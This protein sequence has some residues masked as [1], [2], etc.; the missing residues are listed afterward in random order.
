MLR[1]HHHEHVD[2][3]RDA[4]DVRREL[5]Q[6]EQLL[7]L[8]DD[9]PGFA[10]LS[11]H[12]IDLT[13]HVDRTEQADHRLLRLPELLNELGNVV[14]QERFAFLLETGDHGMTIGRVRSRQPE[15]QRV[16]VAARG[17]RLDSGTCGPV[18]VLGKRLR[19]D[20]PQAYLAVR[21]CRHFLEK[22]SHARRIGQHQ[23]RLL[24]RRVA[25]EVEIQI[26]RFLQLPHHLARARR[27]GIEPV[28]SQVQAHAAQRDVREHDHGQEDDREGE[29]AAHAEARSLPTPTR[30]A[31]SAFFSSRTRAVAASQKPIRAPK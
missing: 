2:V 28:L 18:F 27:Q 31:H 4:I 14:F 21:A 12:R 15:E 22:F 19:I 9:G 24:R 13:L 3:G 16:A 7:D 17:Q 10:H 11:G 26:D 29:E 20:D 5:T 1:L 6:G 30:H 25:R 8:G 23:R